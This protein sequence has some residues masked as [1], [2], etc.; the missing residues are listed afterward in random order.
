MLTSKMRLKQVRRN[1][2]S[3]ELTQDAPENLRSAALELLHSI[4]QKPPDDKYQCVVLF[5][6]NNWG[7]IRVKAKIKLF[8]SFL[9]FFLPL[10]ESYKN[11]YL[12][13]TYSFEIYLFILKSRQ[14]C[15]PFALLWYLNQVDDADG[16]GVVH[17]EI[18]KIQFIILL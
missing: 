3:C 18:M 11:V 4:V 12:C 9:Q 7:K 14:F 2:P 17:T 8:F 1:L 6:K 13:I 16:G 15:N 5:L 10:L